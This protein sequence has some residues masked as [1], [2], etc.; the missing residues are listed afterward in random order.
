MKEQPKVHII[1][2]QILS[3]NITKVNDINIFN[4]LFIVWAFSLNK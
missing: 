1:F 2:D 4:R 3:S